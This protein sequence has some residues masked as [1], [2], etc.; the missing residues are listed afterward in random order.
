MSPLRH[1]PPGHAQ[2]RPSRIEATADVTTAV[3][4]DEVHNDNRMIIER[5]CTREAMVDQRLIP[6]DNMLIHAHYPTGFIILFSDARL[7]DHD[8][9]YTNGVDLGGGTKMRFMPWT[10]MVNTDV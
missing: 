3:L 1:F 5:D 7:R 6:G 9:D 4:S 10:R 8:L 2:R